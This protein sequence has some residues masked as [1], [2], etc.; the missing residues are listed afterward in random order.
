MHSRGGARTRALPHL[1]RFGCLNEASVAS[2]VSY[3]ARPVNAS[4]RGE[5]WT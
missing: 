2:E 1:T 5:A 4:R 3:E